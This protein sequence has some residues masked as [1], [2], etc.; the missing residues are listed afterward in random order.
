MP[1]VVA[2]ID[3]VVS[4][5]DH[6]HESPAEAVSVTLSPSQNV[7][8]PSA[9][10]TAEGVGLTVTLV[11]AEVAVQPLVVVVTVYEP[12]VV[13][14]IDCVVAP[15]DQE[16]ESAADD[17]SVTLPPVQNVVGPSAVIV[18]VGAVQFVTLAPLEN[19]DVPSST[20]PAEQVPSENEVAVATTTSPAARLPAAN[21][22]L[23][24]KSFPA[25]H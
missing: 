5:V 2:T 15:F 18:G 6:D 23:V 8:G 20:A 22:A 12:V 24:A 25:V 3:C 17:V 9:V 19:S 11:A 4:P 16:Y 21:V 10:M 13:T 14:T 7:V 1:A